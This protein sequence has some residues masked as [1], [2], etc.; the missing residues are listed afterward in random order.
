MVGAADAGHAFDFEAGLVSGDD[1]A[2]VRDGLLDGGNLNL[3]GVV[4]DGEGAGLGAVF[5]HD[6][7]VQSGEGGFS[8]GSVG[9]VFKAGYGEFEGSSGTG[10]GAFSLGALSSLGCFL[11]SDEA[12]EGEQGCE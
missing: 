12:A 8:F 9:L 7:A 1:E 10:F 6:D 11:G 5:A 3:G 2:G 4:V